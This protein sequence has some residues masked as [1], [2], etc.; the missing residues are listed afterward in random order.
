MNTEKYVCL[1]PTDHENMRQSDTRV[2]GT[3]L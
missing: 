3:Y 2:G 1:V